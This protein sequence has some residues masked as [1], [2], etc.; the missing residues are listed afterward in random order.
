METANPE[1]RTAQ[2]AS[3]PMENTSSWPMAYDLTNAEAVS[4]LRSTNS[5]VKPDLSRHEYRVIKRI[6]DIVASGAAIAILLIPGV[7]LSAVIVIKSPGAS[8]FY[9]QQR[10]GRLKADGSYYLFP[11]I[12][13][14]SMVPHA[15]EMLKDLKDKN[16]ADGPLFKIKEDP[17]V[18]PGVGKWIRKHSIDELPQLFN[19]FVGQMS[20]IG[21]RPALPREVLEYDAKAKQRLTVKCGCGGP[22]QAGARSDTSFDEMIALDLTYIA[23]ASPRYDLQLMWQ[24]VKAM[25]VGDGAY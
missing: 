10:V 24:T 25:V 6:F 13:F 16:E 22:W 8:P 21:P 3:N 18:I 15:D 17:R 23:N 2:A 9:T 20:L 19:V 7:I 14:R 12:K 1:N 4:I 5:G 11:M